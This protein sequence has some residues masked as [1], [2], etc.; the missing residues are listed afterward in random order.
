MPA[1]NFQKQFAAAV[2]RGDKLCTIRR[3]APKV[4]DTAY[5]YTGM[6]SKACRKLGEGVITKV[7]LISITSDCVITSDRVVGGL[8]ALARKD[9]FA[10]A[11]AF[12]DFFKTT[13]GDDFKGFL[14]EWE[15]KV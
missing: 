14:I 3:N 8:D 12:L 11:Q 2:E 15:P 7:T 1:Y 6:R 5:L 10:T 4:G 13:Y 9:G